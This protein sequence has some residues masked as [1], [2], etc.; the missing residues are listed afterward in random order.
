MQKI[1][2]FEEAG[3]LNVITDCNKTGVESFLVPWKRLGDSLETGDDED[4]SIWNMAGDC[5]ARMT[6]KVLNGELHG[7]TL[8]WHY[9]FNPGICHHKMTTDGVLVW[10]KTKKTRKSQMHWVCVMEFKQGKMIDKPKIRPV[11]MKRY[12]CRNSLRVFFSSLPLAGDSLKC[13]AEW[14]AG[15]GYV[16]VIVEW[17]SNI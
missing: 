11:I 15:E 8:L 17:F 9:C 12:R 4:E 16:P 10:S 7:T 5:Y 14:W 3:A 1:I 6:G 2:K 13:C